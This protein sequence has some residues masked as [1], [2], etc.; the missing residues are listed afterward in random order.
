MR[1][2]KKRWAAAA[3][4]FVL[5]ATLGGCSD[6]LDVENPNNL[7]EDDLANPSGAK[8]IAN[9]ASGMVA[10]GLGAMYGPYNVATDEAIWT[11]SRDAWREL[12][13]GNLGEP[14]NEFTDAAFQDWAA[15]RW[16]ADEAIIRLKA[17]DDEKTLLDRKHLARAYFYGAIAYMATADMFDDF[18]LS[19]KRESGQPIGDA[20]MKNLYDTAIN[21]AGEAL[22]IARATNDKTLEAT[23]LAL[24]ARAK[25]SKAIWA[26]VNP[27]NTASPLVTDAGAV[28]DAQAALAV[29][30]SADWRYILTLSTDDIAYGTGETPIAYN[31]NQRRELQL[32]PTYV[33]LTADK[34]T[35]TGTALKDP[36]DNKA[37]PVVVSEV[38]KFT[39]SYVN[40]PMTIVSSREM[41][42]IIAEDALARGDLVGF[43]TAIN[44]LRALDTL[45]PYVAQVPALDLLKH[46]RQANLFLQGRRLADL[47]R[48]GVK[49]P[50]WAGNATASTAPGT[51]FPI[52]CIEI[53]ANANL[54]GTC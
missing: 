21:Y 18:A 20:N 11:G 25:F 37:A 40:Q 43:T 48:F 28:A 38:A 46:S 22:K 23:A 8:S 53:R 7:V 14:R 17:F 26:K 10:R 47:Y 3:L 52:T 6:I 12:D 15:G 1:T 5:V 31:V 29:A 33:T 9:G 24:S 36:I 34:R 41:H 30:P 51:F 4:S 13:A 42:L 2:M 32:G 19:N 49:S 45:T 16:M 44:K 50:E 54:A 39:A 27:V 35:I